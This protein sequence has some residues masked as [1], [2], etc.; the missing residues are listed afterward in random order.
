MTMNV[1]T[2]GLYLLVMHYLLFNFLGTEF[3]LAAVDNKRRHAILVGS[4][5][6]GFLLVSLVSYGFF[7]VL[8]PSLY[9]FLPFTIIFSSTALTWYLLKFFGAP[10]HTGGREMFLVYPLAL[11]SFWLAGLYG[12]ANA[13]WAFMDMLGFG[14]MPGLA[15]GLAIPLTVSLQQKFLLNSGSMGLNGR[16]LVV[17]TAAM[18]LLVF[19]F[20]TLS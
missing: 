18:I 10:I 14:L 17:A 6:G 15:F 12:S 5:T 11:N 13:H 4:V 19:W 20:I 16:S 7:K 8:P 2:F 9:W 1:G 3:L